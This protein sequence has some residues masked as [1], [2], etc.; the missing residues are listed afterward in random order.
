MLRMLA[1]AEWDAPA[2]PQGQE[3]LVGIYQSPEAL[4]RFEDL[5]ASSGRWSRVRAVLVEADAGPDSLNRLRV[6]Y[7][8]AGNARRVD[9]ILRLVRD[10][11][12][13]TLG[14]DP[15]FL[16]EGGIVRFD[17][18]EERMTFD[19][20]AGRAKANG[21][22]FSPRLLQLAR[23]V[24]DERKLLDERRERGF[25]RVEPSPIGPVLFA[26]VFLSKSREGLVR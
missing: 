4:R 1:F 22:T 26:G 25:R 3:L 5:L 24:E 20:H 6:I 10:R 21:I 11:P 23:R 12:I 13:L 17:L 2:S 7:F 8:P 19:I 16:A 9:A 14:S 15:A 18:V